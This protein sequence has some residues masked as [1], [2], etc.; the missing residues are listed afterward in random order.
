MGY[1]RANGAIGI[2]LRENGKHIAHSVRA[3]LV[4][5]PVPE[6]EKDRGCD[7]PQL[8][9]SVFR[10]ELMKQRDDE[11]AKGETIGEVTRT[12]EREW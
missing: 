7:P 9:S 3:L 12:L 2:S 6:R 8:K 11:K 10:R 5:A 1:R 4:S